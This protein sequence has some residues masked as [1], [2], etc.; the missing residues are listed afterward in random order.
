[1][2]D[3]SLV[4][5]TDDR[6][7]RRGLAAL[8]KRGSNMRPVFLKLKKPFKQD[9]KEHQKRKEGPDGS[10]WAP[11]TDG[12]KSRDRNAKTVKL[13]NGKTRTFK[14][15]RKQKLLGKLPTSVSSKGSSKRFR[16]ESKI[17]WA[18][19]HQEGATVGNGTVLPARPFLFFS[20]NFLDLADREITE[21]LRLGWTR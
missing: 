16:G 7:V 10:S 15:R 13:K 5:N 17:P 6:D 9:L 19:A 18:D 11:R 1:V 12:T 14:R 8:R 20:Q 3:S 4:V 21:H 2:A